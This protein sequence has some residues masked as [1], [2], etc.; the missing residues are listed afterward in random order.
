MKLRNLKLYTSLQNLYTFTKYTGFDPE[1][2]SYNQNARLSNVDN[3]HYPN[4]RTYTLGL[5]VEF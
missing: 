1:L 5:N 2:G 4:P 3:G